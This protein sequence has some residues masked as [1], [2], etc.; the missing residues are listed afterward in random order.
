[1]HR[2]EITNEQWVRL[3]P[4]LPPQHPT[5]KGGRPPEDHRQVINGIMWVQR[6][7]APW[8]D[9]PERYGNWK[10]VSS[11]FYRWQKAGI[12]Q[13]ILEALQQ[14]AHENGDLDW[15]ENY[16]D[17]SV[18]R[19]HQHAAG[20]KNSGADT[21]GLG[22]SRG[23]FSTK[24]HIRADG[25]GRPL[26]FVVTPGQR[27]DSV[28][29]EQL[30]DQGKVRRSTAGRPRLRPVRIVG[31]KAYSSAKIRKL[32]RKRGIRATIPTPSNQRRLPK[33][34]HEAYRW[35]SRVERLINR[36]KQLRRVATRYEKRAHNYLAMLTIAAILIWL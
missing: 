32:L 30:L 20:A 24:V 31:D 18:V 14:Q 1:M 16:V 6:T 36:L 15:N 10:T 13:R 34:D 3:K 29:F 11:R 7:G 8:R 12:W 23:G 2:G 25:R 28:V 22:R 4:L 9:L 35:R 33:F 21:E 19:A 26:T 17:S 27:H 5:K